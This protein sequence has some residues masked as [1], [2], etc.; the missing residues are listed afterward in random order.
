MNRRS[1]WLLLAAAMLFGAGLNVEPLYD[2]D[3]AWYGQI[4]KELLRSGDWGTLTYRG[5]PFFDKPPLAIW[6]MA[7]AVKLLGPAEWVIRLP[8]ALCGIATVAVV[9][10]IGRM[11]FERERAAWLSAA[12]LVTT[13]PFVRAVRFAMLDAPLTL[14]FS[15]GIAAYLAARRDSRW[16]L[17]LGLS[18]GLV[19]FIKGP[20]ALLLLAIL[21]TFALWERDA[22]VFRSPWWLLGLLGGAVLVL[23]WYALEWQRHGMAFVSAHFGTHVLGRASVAMD[24][25]REPVT[26]YLTRLLAEFHPHLVFLV[27]ALAGMRRRL[28]E[29]PVR[30]ALCWWGGVFAAF[31]LAA[32]K[33][34]WYVVPAY[35]GLALLVGGWLDGVLERQAPIIRLGR[36]FTGYGVVLLVAGAGYLLGFAAPLDRPYVLAVACL[37]SGITLAGWRFMRGDAR[38][39]IG[40][41]TGGAWLAFLA[42]VPWILHWETRESPSYRPLARAARQLEGIAA[43]ATLNPTIRPSFM[44]YLDRPERLVTRDELVRAWPEIG[45]AVLQEAEW[46]GLR[47]LLPGARVLERAGGLVLITR[48]SA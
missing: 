26:F 43:I 48:S 40:L 16:G 29:P 8:S 11:L 19:W 18:L 4:V 31:S 2:W 34:P 25:H 36:V 35:P 9:L 23:P 45:A 13:L 12:V 3:E 38:R 24:G 20:L 44:Y 21:A 1:I 17:G 41:V 33:L 7:L 15:C 22:R 42:L 30:L 14:A 5:E 10:A 27:A 47:V 32:T 28:H 6:A 39:G 46:E 37:G